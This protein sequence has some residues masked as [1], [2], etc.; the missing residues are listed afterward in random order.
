MRAELEPLVGKEVGVRFKAEK[1]GYAP[2]GIVRCTRENEVLIVKDHKLQKVAD[3]HHVW[4]QRPPRE[5]IEAVEGQVLRG[6]GVVT[7]YVKAG[8]IID[9]SVQ[10][11]K[12]IG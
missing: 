10:V 5:L 8:G 6:I 12:V 2:H 9:Y 11:R 1:H 7:R 3:I 4:Q